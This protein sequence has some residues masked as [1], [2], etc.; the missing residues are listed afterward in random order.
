M[1]VGIF[2]PYLDSLGGGERYTLTIAEHLSQNHQVEIFWES[3]N[4]KEQAKRIFALNLTKTRIVDNIFARG[5]SLLEKLIKSSKYDLIFY[6]SDGSLPITLAKSNFLHF[7]TPFKHLKGKTFI[8]RWK[9]SRFNWVICNSYFTKRIID[10]TYG[11]KST[12]LYPPVDISSFTPGKKR[13]LIL[14]VSRFTSFFGAKKQEVMIEVFKNLIDEGLSGWEFYLAGGLLESD[15]GYFAKLKKMI[16]NYPIKLLANVPF[17]E[18]KQ[19]YGQAK[20]Y[21]HAAGFGEDEKQHPELFEHFGISVVE[22]MAAGAVPIVFNGGGLKE[23]ITEN[24]GFLWSTKPELKTITLK[25]IN[26][27]NQFLELSSRA[28]KRAQNFSKE[29]FLRRFDEIMA[30]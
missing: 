19:Y 18:I 16:N 9:L 17:K 23:I 29:L 26:D 24:S 28:K 14:N 1:K 6:L 30:R 5:K 2:D 8:N 13:N 15:R 20:I 10:E 21:W 25:L 11:L 7:Q 4:L 27:G 22:A 12:V 3:E